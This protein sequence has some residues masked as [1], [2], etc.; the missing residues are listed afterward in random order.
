MLDIVAPPDDTSPLLSP[1]D[2]PVF[3]VFNGEGQTP[4][5]IVCDHASNRIP[6]SMGTLGLDPERLEHHIA[7]D[8]GAAE[9]VGRL[10][11][12]LDAPAV[13]S[14]FSRLVIDCNRQPGDPQAVPHKSDGVSVPGNTEL[15]EEDEVLRAETFH[16]PYHHAI[17]QALAHI[18]RAGT[19]PWLF[20]VHSFTPRLLGGDA[21]KWDIGVM[22]NRDHRLAAPMI[23]ML[24]DEG[25]HVGDNEPYS[26]REIA[27]TLERHAMGAGLPHVAVEIRQDLLRTPEGTERWATLLGDVFRELLTM[28]ALHGVEHF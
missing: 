1:D 26:A 28:D 24:R 5:L 6:L 13:L 9:V 10:A 27:Y 16:E 12:R 3:R 17:S 8:I 7:Y 19:A 23:E 18:W 4:L 2:P 22:W 15:S 21:R 11:R 25:L 14:G 20:S